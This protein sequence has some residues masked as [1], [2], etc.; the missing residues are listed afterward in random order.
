MK[1]KILFRDTTDLMVF[2]HEPWLEMGGSH[3]H[4]GEDM[5]LF[6]KWGHN[7]KIDGLA[8]REGLTAMVIH[9]D[10]RNEEASVLD[11]GAEYYI[12]RINTPSNG[13]Y[14]VVTRN[15]GNYVLDEKGTF[16]GGTRR[17]YPDATKAVFYNQYA[18]TFVPAGHGIEG[19]PLHCGTTLEI[20][21][22]LWKS[23]RAGDVISLGVYF[24]NEPL[25]G[26]SVD[27]AINGPD[28]YLQWQDMTRANGA[29]YVFAEKPGRYL[30]VAR[31]SV[32]EGE[33]GVYDELSLTATL[34]FMVTK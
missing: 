33:E 30:V 25:D 21:P 3:A 20:R 19:V 1:T 5:N 23:W 4:A 16:Q 32:P 12:V 29:L 9:P 10:G 2:G 6:L 22:A 11:G 34:A 31:Y 26:I 7:M 28:G 13:L 17:E 18:Q 27:I 8:R 15:E 24:R 14:H